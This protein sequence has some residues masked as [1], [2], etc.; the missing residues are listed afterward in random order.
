MSVFTQVYIYIYIC[1][2]CLYMRAI[3]MSV[4]LRLLVSSLWLLGLNHVRVK[5]TH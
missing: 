1:A 4:L 2:V 5:V 3:N